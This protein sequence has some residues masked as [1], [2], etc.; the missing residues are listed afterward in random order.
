MKSLVQTR[1]RSFILPA[2]SLLMGVAFAQEPPKVT[3]PANS[4]YVSADGEF[5]AEPDTA[6]VQFTISAQADTSENA[7]RQAS[8]ATEQARKALRANGIEPKSAQFGI[9]SLQPVYEYRTGKQRLIGYRVSANVS[10][11]LTD[12]SKVAGLIQSLSAIDQTSQQ[13][14]S[15]IL[16]NEETAK[17]K[18]IEDAY[19]RAR[20]YAQTIAKAAGRNVG[21]LFYST[22]DA[23]G[24]VVPVPMMARA[25]AD[26]AEAVP[27][28]TEQFTP[29]KVTMHAHVTAIFEMSVR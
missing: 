26:K 9:Y 12:F 27:A 20:A 13:S 21:E 23:S 3:A 1:L 5:E 18:A 15:Y 17:L 7:Y 28:P 10:L 8:E 24:G 14:V 4:I 2:L 6:L 25:M 29:Q 16:E 19:A 11:K 22:V